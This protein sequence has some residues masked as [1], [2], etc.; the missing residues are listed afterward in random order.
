[1]N[2]C[3]FGPYTIKRKLIPGKQY[4]DENALQEFVIAFL[5]QMV[6]D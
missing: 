5:D 2:C 1:M 6:L 3:D 4:H